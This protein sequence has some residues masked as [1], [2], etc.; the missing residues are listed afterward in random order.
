M[1]GRLTRSALFLHARSPAF[2]CYSS[3]PPQSYPFDPTVNLEA[4]HS[5]QYPTFLPPGE[6]GVPEHPATLEEQNRIR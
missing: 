3:Q 4:K 6:S 1:G 5:L 2:Y